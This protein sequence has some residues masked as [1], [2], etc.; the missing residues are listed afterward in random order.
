MDRHAHWEHIFATK[1]EHGVSWYEASPTVSLRLMEAAGLSRQSC[2]LDVGGGDSRLV[3]V[4]VERGLHCLAVL[5][6]S[7]AALRRVQIRLGSAAEVPL[8]I[9]ADV[10]ADWSV[11]PMDIWHDRAVFHFLTEPGDRIRYLEHLR[12]TLKRGGAAIIGTF[13]LDGPATCSGL[14]VVRYS[15]NTLAAELG[16]DFELV[17]SVPHLHHTPWGKTQTFQYSR[18]TRV[19]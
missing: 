12:S 8:W 3:D 16:H 13:A 9:A 17:E 18:F 15:A 7:E 14:S 1:A 19:H 6:I 5:D 2:V 4:L 11:D 10:T